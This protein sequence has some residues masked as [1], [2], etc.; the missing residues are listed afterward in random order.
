MYGG[1][2]RLSQDGGRGTGSGFFG[3]ASPPNSNSNRTRPMSAGTQLRQKPPA[4]SHQDLFATLGIDASA[5]ARS[6]F[7]SSRGSTASRSSMTGP[8][9]PTGGNMPP[10]VPHSRYG[11]PPQ[12]NYSAPPPPSPATQ[13][14]WSGSTS[15][16]AHSTTTSSSTATSSSSFRP[17]PVSSAFAAA[18]PVAAPP[19]KPTTNLFS[20]EDTDAFEMG[21]GWQCDSPSAV[22]SPAGAVSNPKD[23]GDVGLDD[24]GDDDFGWDE[25]VDK[26][27]GITPP[28]PASALSPVVAPP[29]A[30]QVSAPPPTASTSFAYTASGAF[31]SSQAARQP[32]TSSV[33]AS[34]PA[35]ASVPGVAEF[36]SHAERDSWSESWG[37]SSSFSDQK[38]ATTAVS[39]T[40]PLSA[41]AIESIPVANE[42]WGDQDDDALFDE[43][44]HANDKWDESPVVQDA[45]ASVSRLSLQ[46][47]E[48]AAIAETAD[49]HQQPQYHQPP[50]SLAPPPPQASQPSPSSFGYSSGAYPFQSSRTSFET[51]QAD[52][53]A[54]SESHGFRNGASTPSRSSI[55]GTP[56]PSRPGSAGATTPSR[57][58]STG[59]SFAAEKTELH[60]STT[61]TDRV[62]FST[63][64]TFSEQNEFSHGTSGSALYAQKPSPTESPSASYFATPSPS[65]DEFAAST[66]DSIAFS[67]PRSECQQSSGFE[68]N[69]YQ[70]QE[71]AQNDHQV[72]SQPEKGWEMP[73]S[74]GQPNEDWGNDDGEMPSQPIQQEVESDQKAI[75]ST[76]VGSSNASTAFGTDFPSVSE[77]FSA[78]ATTFGGSD[79]VSDGQFSD[80]NVSETPSLNE[81]SSR[82]AENG[83]DLPPTEKELPAADA[84][85]LFGSTPASPGFGNSFVQPPQQYDQQSYQ[86]YDQG[87][88]YSSENSAF[89]KSHNQYESTT[90]FAAVTAEAT[91]E[92]SHAQGFFGYSQQH[93]EQY[94]Q[95]EKE[96]SDVP[97]ENAQPSAHGF[98]GEDCPEKTPQLIKR[99]EDMRC[100]NNRFSNRLI[101]TTT[102]M[103]LTHQQQAAPVLRGSKYKDPCV[104]APSCLASFG[105]GGNV[106]TMFPKRKLRLNIAGSSFRNSPR[107]PVHFEQM[108]K[109]PGPLTENVSE[110]TIL[111]YLDEQL[112]DVSSSTSEQ[113][114]ERLLLGILNILVKCNGKLRSDSS[115][116][117]S[118][119]DSPEVQLVTLLRESDQHRRGNRPA[120]FPP[121]KPVQTGMQPAIPT[122]FLSS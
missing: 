89:S 86:S 103:V 26:Q 12:D 41:P 80:G 67:Q 5:G 61:S 43:D 85:D 72:P 58:S 81:S 116:N 62:S 23:E 91:Q 114:D 56:T 32:T 70:Q 4:P 87:G 115:G 20:I 24:L 31:S 48:A 64:A 37:E 82:S 52:E 107:A 118:D 74:Y 100:T 108:E 21:D 42:F 60:F 88:G 95:S 59:V 29:L 106:V 10:S 84:G 2:R 30:V 9:P 122:R 18:P 73:E 75:S 77:G 16:F 110:Q 101:R 105:F 104:P 96:A 71:Q 113:E 90:S 51:P 102:I 66:T 7:F 11:A 99:L 27:F 63:S 79:Y 57:P 111:Q 45:T 6:S 121:P 69:D 39:H 117:P 97:E 8:P 94:G 78:A 15:R 49:I 55:T 28:K 33:A 112:K 3:V 44:E 50:T 19:A 35:A 13:T 53:H 65:K 46:E 76:M 38:E 109:F 17:P 68:N 98:F 120:V 1:D 36:G 25:E 54:S 83:S 47:Q 40:A 119:P 14:N 22:L 93:N 92:S 34:A